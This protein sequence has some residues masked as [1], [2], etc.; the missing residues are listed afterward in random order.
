MPLKKPDPP[1][2]S[3][4]QLAEFMIAKSARQREI[5]RRNKFKQDFL[6]VYYK[7]ASEAV[8]LCLSSNMTDLYI[9]ENAISSLEQKSPD[10]IGTQRRL[11]A[12]IG[13]LEAFQSMLD[14]INFGEASP[15]LGEQSPPRLKFHGVEVSVR[16]EIVLS[17][18][19]K[20]GKQLI[21]ATKLYMS[22]GTPLTDTSAG[23]ISAALQEHCRRN[24]SHRGDYSAPLC[25]VID[26]GSKH[27]FPGVK[28]TAARIK[29]I[30]A[31]CQNIAA[32]WDSITEQS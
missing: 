26:V 28:A 30:E 11:T 17:A 18:K 8:S 32:L 10:K 29:D 2:I 13:A 19:G 14:D 12:N 23:Y 27:V 22:R 7:E 5:I 24:L 20:A 16:P 31:A 4:N 9:I 21:G 25:G 1:R 3:I 15:E 6:V